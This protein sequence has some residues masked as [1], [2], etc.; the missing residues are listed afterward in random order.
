MTCKINMFWAGKRLGKLSTACMN[1]FLRMGHEVVLHCYAPPEDMPA[2]V[3]T[4]DAAQLLPEEELLRHRKT[5]SVSLGSNRYR[6]LLIEAG[7]GLYA[8]CDM[9]CVGDI[10]D[11]GYVFGQ[12]ETGRINGAMLHYPPGSEL[13]KLLLEATQSRYSMPLGISRSKQRIFGAR[14]LIGVPRS[15]ETIKWGVWGPNLLTHAVNT[16]DLW[17]R[18]AAIDIYYPVHFNQTQ[19]FYEQGLSLADITTPRTKAVHLYHAG[20]HREDPAE[21]TPMHEILSLS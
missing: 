8:D 1:S 5:G 9:F 16:L 20:H 13:S 14:R 2:G 19:L 17:D 3:A 10:E 21:G 7:L 6:Y 4:F 18:S 15:V 11:E 12:E